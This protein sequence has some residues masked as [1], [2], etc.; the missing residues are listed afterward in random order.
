M[1]KQ[2]RTE[3]K[4]KG[5][6]LYLIG[7]GLGIWGVALL[8]CCFVTPLLGLIRGLN[9]SGS[10]TIQII[11]VTILIV[12]IMVPMLG[13]LLV[14]SFGTLQFQ[15]LHNHKRK[16]L[17]EQNK[18]HM[19][20]FWEAIKTKDFDEAKRL[21]NIDSFIGGSERVLCNGILMGLATQLPIDHDWGKNVYERMKSYL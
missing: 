14:T 17:D 11:I 8:V 3:I 2:E 6:K 18:F 1:N 10:E 20:L 13:S 9:E 12:L 16:L 4:K 15:K 5:K 21:Y 19:S 7:Y